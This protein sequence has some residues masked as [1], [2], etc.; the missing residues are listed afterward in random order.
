MLFPF[1]DSEEFKTFM[2]DSYRIIENY[3]SEMATYWLSFMNMVEVLMMNIHSLKVQDWEMLKA[4]L[5]MMIAWMQIYDSNNY[6]KLAL[7][8]MK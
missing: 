7:S 5:R 1:K 2:F 3:N 6:G 4:S 8:L